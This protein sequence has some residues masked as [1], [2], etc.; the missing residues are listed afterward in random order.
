MLFVSNSAPPP[1][2][3]YY[4]DT[5]SKKHNRCRC[6]HHYYYFLTRNANV[7]EMFTYW[8]I[9]SLIRL[10]TRYKLWKTVTKKNM[11]KSPY[12][13]TVLEKS[14]GAVNIVFFSCLH[15]YSNKI[16]KN[17]VLNIFLAFP[18]VAVHFENSISIFHKF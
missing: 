2:F 4:T 14:K 11:K 10:Y 5:Y 1:P 15:I 7:Y 12:T 6:R 16:G 13:D 18:C 17:V 3:N 9:H 8:H